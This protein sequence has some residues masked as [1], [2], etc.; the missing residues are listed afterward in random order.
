MRSVTTAALVPLVLALGARDSAAQSPAP[1]TCH[2]SAA[3]K[4]IAGSVVDAAT[5][6]P[7]V[8]VLAY[9]RASRPDTTLRD[10]GVLVTPDFVR[11]TDLD[12]LGRFC[13][14]DLRTGDYRLETRAMRIDASR[15]AVKIRLSPSDSLKSITLRYRPFGRSPEDEEGLNKALAVLDRNRR[16]WLEVRP[17]HYLLQVKRDC[18]CFGGPPPTFEVLNGVPVAALDTGVRRALYSGETGL[19]IEA[20]FDTL[21]ASMLDERGTVDSIVYDERFGWP[22]QYRTDTRTLLTDS[23][24]TL[25]VERFEVIP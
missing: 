5:G 1:M 3:R 17:A 15:Q 24:A 25:T 14:E 16:R 18:F 2:A 9:L 21:R 6:A 12:T 8:G 22:R 19:T 13:F 7:M 20:V 23:W 10:R 4:A 11:R